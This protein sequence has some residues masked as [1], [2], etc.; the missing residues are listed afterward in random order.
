[1]GAVYKARDTRLERTVAIKVL[2]P[3]VA[4]DPALN[5]R[6]QREARML[7]ALSH[8]HMCPIFDVGHQNDSAFLVRQYLDGETLAERLARGPL[9]L[10]QA[11]LAGRNVTLVVSWPR[12]AQSRRRFPRAS[13]APDREFRCLN[14]MEARMDTKPLSPSTWLLFAVVVVIATAIFLLVAERP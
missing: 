2:P 7:A 1:M 8:P 9:P 5:Q 11:L 12:S 6:L 3:D 4:G 10:D 14:P 13:R